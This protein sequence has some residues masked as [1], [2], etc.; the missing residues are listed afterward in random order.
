MA[1]RRPARRSG[2]GETIGLVCHVNIARRDQAAGHGSDARG[3]AGP[4]PLHL[5]G[6]RRSVAAPKQMFLP[7][8]IA[9]ER[10]SL[11]QR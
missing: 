2:V 4:P 6:A 10:G 1:E 9:D 3:A 11:F 5:H 8:I 7:P